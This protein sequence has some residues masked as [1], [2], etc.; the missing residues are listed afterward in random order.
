MYLLS[1]LAQD[2]ETQRKGFVGI[3]MNMDTFK[4]PVTPAES[5]DIY[6][7]MGNLA[8]IRYVGF[9]FCNDA[10]PRQ[11]MTSNYETTVLPSAQDQYTFLRL[12][13]H[14]GTSTTGSR[15]WAWALLG[16]L[17]Y[18]YLPYFPCSTLGSLLDVH[19][20]LMTFGIPTK[21]LPVT[22]QGEADLQH[23][24]D[25]ITSRKSIEAKNLEEAQEEQTTLSEETNKDD[26]IGAPPRRVDV[27]MGWETLGQSHTGN[28]HY[29]FLIDEFQERYD[30]CETSIEKTM[31]ALAIVIKVKE[32]GGRFLLRKKGETNWSEADDW[33]AREKVTN[34]FRGRRKSALA[35]LKRITEDTDKS[36]RRLPDEIAGNDFDWF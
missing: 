7:F 31:L 35:R 24:Y 17:Q 8:P 18:Q 12:R 33:V 14:A 23:H 19:Y 16:L 2:E 36:K 10:D 13:F 11:T 28:T 4:W 30:A 34:A 22:A 26:C 21:V 20:D 1:V 29:Q 25:W 15:T 6:H 32:Y 27:L 3:F 9:H 5:N